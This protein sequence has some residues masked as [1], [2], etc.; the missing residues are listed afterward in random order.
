MKD[1]RFP[2]HSPSKDDDPKLF[3]YLSETF[4]KENAVIQLTNSSLSL[5]STHFSES[6]D[7]YFDHFLEDSRAIVRN[8][9]TEQLEC[10][11]IT[12]ILHLL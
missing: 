7:S 4:A 10:I 9:P 2:H 8:K 6:I 5:I 11:R 3:V 12:N 1:N